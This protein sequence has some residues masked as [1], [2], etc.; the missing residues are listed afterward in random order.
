MRLSTIA[1][2]LLLVFPPA[3]LACFEHDPEQTKMVPGGAVF[4][5]GRR[6]GRAWERR[7]G[8]GHP[9]SG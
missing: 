3:V 8:N 4:V 7:G 1:V 5:R 9:D 2:C 6:R